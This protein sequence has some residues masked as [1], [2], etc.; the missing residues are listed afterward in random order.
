V[1]ESPRVFLVIPTRGNRDDTLLP[2]LDLGLPTVLVHTVPD[3]LNAP[4]MSPEY[5]G[6]HIEYLQVSQFPVNISRWWNAGTGR[7]KELGADTCVIMNDD[8]ECR[9]AGSVRTLGVAASGGLSYVYPRTTPG[10][11]PI[12]GW[13]FGIDPRLIFPDES[14]SFWCGEDDMYIRAGNGGLRLTGVAFPDGA[15]APIRHLR[16]EHYSRDELHG[17]LGLQALI[18]HDIALF[19]SRWGSRGAAMHTAEDWHV[20]GGVQDPP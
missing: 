6:K 17:D 11:T 13:C 4:P 5:A 19:G 20:Y 3:M 10:W 2:L 8:V 14:Y 18:D 7:A 16:S 1:S 9:D 15:D 12:T